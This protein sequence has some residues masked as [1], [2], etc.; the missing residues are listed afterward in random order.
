MPTNSSEY[1]SGMRNGGPKSADDEL[2]CVHPSRPPILHICAIRF[3]RHR[4]LG[5]ELPAHTLSLR[6]ALR[7]SSGKGTHPSA[8]KAASRSFRHSWVDKKLLAV[9]LCQCQVGNLGEALPHLRRVLRVVGRMVCA[10]FH[11]YAHGSRDHS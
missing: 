6:A 2:G 7:V 9:E 4:C 10:S 5:H 1:S 3:R 11:L 8:A